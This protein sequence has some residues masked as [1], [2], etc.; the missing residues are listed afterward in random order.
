[1]G[2]SRQEYWSRLPFPSPGDLPDPGIEPRSPN[3][4]S[5][6][7]GRRFTLWAT[8]EAPTMAVSYFRHVSFLVPSSLLCT[9]TQ[10]WSCTKKMLLSGTPI[11]VNIEMLL[12]VY[13]YLS[14]CTYIEFPF[15]ATE[16]YSPLNFGHIIL[17]KRLK[18]PIAYKISSLI[19]I[20]NKLNKTQV[21]QVLELACH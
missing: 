21:P 5:H 11:D 18:I 6:I 1:M 19:Y 3:Q 13:V 16:S 12:N 4:V 9:Y 20:S 2:F 8:R 17:L 14:V 10:V 15:R 7:S